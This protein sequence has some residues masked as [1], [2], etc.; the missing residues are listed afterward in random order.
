MGPK[1]KSL[2]SADFQTT[3]AR[4]HFV[5]CGTQSYP[6]NAYQIELFCYA[7]FRRLIQ[8][9]AQHTNIYILF[10]HACMTQKCGLSFFIREALPI[11]FDGF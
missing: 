5:L 3:H 7:S 6:Y 4:T 8:Q 2:M 11:R 1:K 10:E 9:M